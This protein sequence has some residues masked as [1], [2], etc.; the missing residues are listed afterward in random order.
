MLSADDVFSVLSV[1]AGL[2]VVP[3]PVAEL[4]IDAS[5]LELLLA[6][7]LSFASSVDEL[8]VD[9]AVVSPVAASL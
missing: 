5:T 9:V 3:L 6:V 1:V 7:G 2:S 4:S 8:F